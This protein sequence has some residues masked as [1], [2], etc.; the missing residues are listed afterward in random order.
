MIA[1]LGN[2]K[3]AASKPLKIKASNSNL[4]RIILGA[5]RTVL[6]IKS[7]EAVIIGFS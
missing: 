4:G 3:K 6:R 7:K 5:N 2:R 1:G